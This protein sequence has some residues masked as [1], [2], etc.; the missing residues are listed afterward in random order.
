MKTKGKDAADYHGEKRMLASEASVDLYFVWEDDWTLRRPAV[1][2][3]LLKVFNGTADIDF[4]LTTLSK[5]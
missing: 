3:A 1:E 5:G 2:A 4:I